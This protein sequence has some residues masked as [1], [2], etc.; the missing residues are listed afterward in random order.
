VVGAL[1]TVLCCLNQQVA[2]LEQQLA[3]R[4]ATSPDA[5]ILRSQPGLGVVLGARVLA[6]FGDDPHRYA[7]AKGRK[8]FAGT[9]PVTD[10]PG[11]AQWW[12]PGGVQPAASGRLLPVGVRRA[13]RLARR[14]PLLRRPPRPWCQPPSGAAR[15]GQPA[16]RHPARLPGPAGGYQEQLA[17]PAAEP[18]P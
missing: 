4:F 7:T 2:A 11:C 9:A 18:V 12:C 1:V 5:A 6:E 14:M 3:A 10:P 16:G 15:I 13:D 8:A 17:W